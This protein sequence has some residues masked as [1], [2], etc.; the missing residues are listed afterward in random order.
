M[1]D[2]EI[3]TLLAWTNQIDGRVTVNAATHELWAYTLGRVPFPAAKLA[4][5]EFYRVNT[6]RAINAAIIRKHVRNIRETHAGR[7]AARAITAERQQEAISAPA[8]A[9]GPTPREIGRQKAAQQFAAN[10][11]RMP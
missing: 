7:T 4:I 3:S 6:D 5:L 2:A 1:N 11:G 10:L 8:P 9:Q